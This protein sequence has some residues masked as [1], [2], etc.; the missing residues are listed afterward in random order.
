MTSSKRHKRHH[1]CVRKSD[2]FSFH[3]KFENWT[4][5]KISLK[6]GGPSQSES[7]TTKM[8]FK[9]LQNSEQLLETNAHFIVNR[10]CPLSSC[11]TI[12][13][14]WEEVTI[15]TEI[16]ASR[17][18]KGI[19]VG[20][21]ALTLLNT[22]ALCTHSSH[23]SSIGEEK[24]RS[25]S[26]RRIRQDFE[27]Y[28]VNDAPCQE[29][30]AEVLQHEALKTGEEEEDSGQTRGDL[31]DRFQIVP[32]IGFT[33]GPC[34][35]HRKTTAALTP[36]G[37]TDGP[38]SYCRSVLA[39]VRRS[40]TSTDSQVSR[41]LLHD[42][43][44][45]YVVWAANDTIE[46]HHWETLCHPPYSPVFAP[47]DYH[48]FHP[49]DNPPY[50]S[51]QSV[52]PPN[53]T[54]TVGRRRN[55]LV[56]GSP[57]VDERRFQNSL[58]GS[59]HDLFHG[60]LSERKTQSTTILPTH[61]PRTPRRYA[62]TETTHPAMS[63]TKPV[64]V[65]CCPK[66]D[67]H[68]RP[69]PRC[70]NA[71]FADCDTS[72]VPPTRRYSLGSQA[73]MHRSKTKATMAKTSDLPSLQFCLRCFQKKKWLSVILGVTKCNTRASIDARRDQNRQILLN[74]HRAAVDI[75][76]LN[77][78][79]YKTPIES[80][81]ELFAHLLAAA[82]SLQYMPRIFKRVRQAMTV[83]ARPISMAQLLHAG[84]RREGFRV[85]VPG[86][87]CG[88][89]Q[90]S[91]LATNLTSE[92]NAYDLHCQHIEFGENLFNGFLDMASTELSDGI[93]DRPTTDV[94]VPFSI[95]S[96][97]PQFSSAGSV[98]LG[99]IWM[100]VKQGE[101]G[102]SPGCKGGEKRENPEKTR[103]PAGVVRHD[104]HMRKN[105]GGW[106]S[107]HY[108]TVV[109]RLWGNIVFDV[110]S[111]G[112][113]GGVVVILLAS[114][115]EEMG[116]IPGR[117]PPEDCP[118]RRRWP[119]G[120][121]GF[122][123]F[124]GHFTPAL[125]RPSS[126]LNTL[127]FVL[128]NPGAK[129]R[130]AISTG[131]QGVTHFCCEKV[132]KGGG[133]HSP[134]V[135]KLP[136]FRQYTLIRDELGFDSRS[137][138]PDF[139]FPW[140]PEITPGGREGYPCIQAT[141]V[142]LPSSD[143]AGGSVS[144]GHACLAGFKQ[145]PITRAS[146]LWRTVYTVQDSGLRGETSQRCGDHGHFFQVRDEVVNE[147][148]QRLKDTAYLALELLRIEFKMP[149]FLKDTIRNKKKLQTNRRYGGKT[150]RELTTPRAETTWLYTGRPASALVL[151]RFLPRTQAHFS[152][153]NCFVANA[154]RTT[155]GSEHINPV[156]S[157][158]KSPTKHH[159]SI[160]LKEKWTTIPA[161]MYH[162]SMES[163]V[164]R[165]QACDG[166]EMRSCFVLTP[167]PIPVLTLADLI[168]TA[169]ENKIR[170]DNYAELRDTP[171][172]S[173]TKIEGCIITYD[174]NQRVYALQAWHGKLAASLP[175][176]VTSTS[177][178]ICKLSY[179]EF[180]SRLKSGVN[181]A[182]I[183]GDSL[184]KI[185][186][187][188]ANSSRMT[189]SLQAHVLPGFVSTLS[190]TWI[191]TADLSP[192]RAGFN[193]RR[194]HS[195]FSQ[196]GVMPD[197]ATGRRVFFFGDLPFTMPFHSGAAPYLPQSPPSD[198]KTS[199]S[200][201]AE[202]SSPVVGGT[203]E[204]HGD[205]SCCRTNFFTSPP[206]LLVNTRGLNGRGCVVVVTS[207]FHYTTTFQDFL[208]NQGKVVDAYDGIWTPAK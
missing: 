198:L 37:V 160:M 21:G 55:L 75:W 115:P 195:G 19:G 164:G 79:V 185:L 27:N 116:S 91:G 180:V 10:L 127:T 69:R 106:Q 132:E 152:S 23:I 74:G 51:L 107:N 98:G 63:N 88:I 100:R 206:S 28:A 7:C 197:D 8:D 179:C 208:K 110:V 97:G 86:K 49:L 71:L 112:G 181:E 18:G 94:F 13:L 85:R 171:R 184:I 96:G 145:Q 60:L 24:W 66:A 194:V 3:Q 95:A 129:S 76:H 157:H 139:G 15:D 137:G 62:F 203:A 151:R 114:Q 205:K 149:F 135:E 39:A 189:S 165:T 67:L 173:R 58:F 5:S 43:T 121:L 176:N 183:T 103:R 202:I 170:T 147:W 22:S 188:K 196:V 143:R 136:A 204:I 33:T 192:R 156:V 175:W 191:M 190:T 57:D 56:G 87:A 130:D 146:D 92:F 26:I 73:H 99:E 31:A 113:G 154:L 68:A 82:Y 150:A 163:L 48:I 59:D 138:H 134:A 42:K 1:I 144:N 125:L 4:G 119:A 201:A 54:V 124:P 186:H 14:S 111:G 101:Y 159:R 193:A 200:R 168:T 20:V 162:R 158:T 104:P 140:F 108:T 44:M 65:N 177:E 207:R 142:S 90:N 38:N 169:R 81:E 89:S 199:L 9:K 78:L 118:G 109:P 47:T 50:T 167:Y 30:V 155:I 128:V 45:S 11:R 36:N 64:L 84:L 141:A 182:L 174:S 52:S 12:D 77:S 61:S 120:F 148:F 16:C 153:K 35:S 40:A 172:F 93:P 83:V 126:A 29:S 72:G 105:L 117:V 122:S 2:G 32:D 6:F 123:R 70:S 41:M 34:T 187:N 178:A 133:A 80:E 17:A 161:G 102:A 25:A 131:A 53:A 166:S 46:L